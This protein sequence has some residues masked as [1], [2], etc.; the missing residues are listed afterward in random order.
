MSTR[1]GLFV[2]GFLA[3]VVVI[4]IA[5]T[6]GRPEQSGRPGQSGLRPTQGRLASEPP[7]GI[8]V[9]PGFTFITRPSVGTE[10]G[11]LA[12]D[13]GPT[14]AYEVGKARAPLVQE[15]DRAGSLWS[16]RLT[17]PGGEVEV[18]ML[19]ENELRVGFADGNFIGRNVRTNEDVADVLLTALSLH[20][21]EGTAVKR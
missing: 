19:S 17:V 2:A 14:I 16:R 21:D 10:I 3:L 6:R 5:T 1:V 18:Y 12:K 4:A 15:S 9:L 11:Q 20:A 13:R 8:A 7:A